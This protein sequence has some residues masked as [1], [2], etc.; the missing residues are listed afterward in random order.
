VTCTP[1]RTIDGR[2]FDDFD[3]FV[4]HFSSSVLQ[5]EWAWNGNLDA[6]NDILRGGFGTPEER[7]WTLR[8]LHAARSR[9]ALGHAAEARWLAER[10]ERC[11]PTNVAAFRAR[12]E[13]ALADRGPTL[14]DQLVE[15]IRDHGEGGAEAEDGVILDLVDYGPSMRPATKSSSPERPGAGSD[16][17]RT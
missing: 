17:Q 12:R 11:H 7:P 5:G 8:W 10:I 14:F 16:P 4:A 13:E 15:I 9:E 6:F 2:A 1:V 3:G